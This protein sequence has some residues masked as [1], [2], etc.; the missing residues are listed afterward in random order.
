[1]LDCDTKNII[2]ISKFV[3]SLSLFDRV[4]IFFFVSDCRLFFRTN[5]IKGNIDE[6]CCNAKKHR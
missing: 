6:K 1:M 4:N 2:I 5:D 3:F